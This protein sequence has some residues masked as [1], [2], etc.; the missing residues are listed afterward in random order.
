MT[1]QECDNCTYFDETRVSDIAQ[2][3][4]CS[5][6]RVLYRVSVFAC[7]LG[8]RGQYCDLGE[9]FFCLPPRSMCRYSRSGVEE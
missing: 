2:G 5:R 6:F 7:E 3:R 4:G 8:R 1:A 9:W